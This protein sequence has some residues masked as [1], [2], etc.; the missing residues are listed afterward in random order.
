MD[1]TTIKRRQDSVAHYLRFA[2]GP[3]QCQFGMNVQA[4]LDRTE[5]NKKA[6]DG[7]NRQR[8]E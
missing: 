5:G 7:G 2:R 3:W 8:Q 4:A 1:E 6:A